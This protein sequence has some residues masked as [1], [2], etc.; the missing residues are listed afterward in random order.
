[1]KPM[2]GIILSFSFPLVLFSGCLS[3]V[4]GNPNVDFTFITLE[5]QTKQLRD[6]YGTVIVLDLMGVNCQPCGREMTQLKQIQT[7][8]S[9]NNVIIVS[10]DVWV[11][12]GENASLLAQYLDTFREQLHLELNWTFGLDD[13]KGTIEKAYAKQGI[14]ALYILDKKGNIYYTHVGY[15]SYAVLA[16]K[17]DQVMQKG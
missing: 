8:Y 10:V 14:P 2:V 7:N 1:M 15:D 16:S 6:Y 5:G 3:F 9:R 11:S 17:L 4:P 12:S 13:G